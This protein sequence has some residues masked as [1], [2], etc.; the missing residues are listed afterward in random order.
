[1]GKIVEYL[2]KDKMFKTIMFIGFILLFIQMNQV[3]LY[4]DDFSIG[5]LA[6]NGTNIFKYFSEHYRTWGGGYTGCILIF[7]FKIGIFFW[8]IANTLL[9]SIMVMHATKMVTYKNEKYKNIIASTVWGLVFSLGIY[10]SKEC[11][12]WLDGSCAYVLST[13]LM[14]EFIYLIY[15]KLIMRENIKKW[16]YVLF[17]I[18]ALFSGW[19]SAQTGIVSLAIV[20]LIIGY[21]KF[22]NK[23]KIKLLIWISIIICLIG[24]LIFYLSPGNMARMKEFEEYNELGIVRKIMYRV[25]GVYGLIFDVDNY[26]PYEMPFYAFLVM[27]IDCASRTSTF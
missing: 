12:Y 26:E 19:S 16:D 4:A 24:C 3:V 15:S 2:K 25:N 5:I 13:F 7:F 18:I 27:R 22:V 10:V 23:E 1:M 8:K 9:I 21:A 14:F 6:K 17:P 20:I 11:I